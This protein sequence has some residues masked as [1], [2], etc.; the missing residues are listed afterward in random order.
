MSPKPTTIGGDRDTN[1]T[2]AVAKSSAIVPVDTGPI[3]LSPELLPQLQQE[4]AALDFETMSTSDVIRIGFEAE[5]ALNQT[6]DGFIAGLD[7]E[8]AAKVFELFRQLEKGVEDANLPEILEKV[9]VDSPGLLVKIIAAVTRRSREEVIQD[10]MDK[11]GDLIGTRIKDLSRK[12]KSLEGDLDKELQKLIKDLQMLENLKQ[13]YTE[14][15]AD[16][17]FKAALAYAFWQQSKVYVTNETALVASNDMN[18]L[19][20]IQGLERKLQNLENRALIL[21][22]TYS[23]LPADQ[24]VI[25]QIQ[26]AGVSTLQET[27]AVLSSRFASIK[28]TVLAIYGVF[29]VGNVQR[30]NDRSVKMEA[31]LLESR[32]KA[33]K[34][35][36]VKAALAPGEN[37]LAEAQKLA[38]IVEDTKEIKT[39]VTEAELTTNAN[40]DAA[41]QI[42]EDKRTELA[43]LRK[44]K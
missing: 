21:E 32:S 34:Q 33:L 2:K 42:F 11:L 10:L 36:A 17:T 30:L 12:V 5:R 23:R 40:F 39:L 27:A 29:S 38:K 26:Q 8:T 19:A 43:E 28:M 24:M 1:K 16:F 25:E 13:K 14:H 6:L 41:R 18:G 35:V 7:K 9:Q 31:Q 20:R 22:S 4:V 37:R 15:F 44:S 3:V